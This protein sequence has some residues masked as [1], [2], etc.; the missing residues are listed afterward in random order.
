MDILTQGNSETMSCL[1]IAIWFQFWR[2]YSYSNEM[3]LFYPQ[4]SVLASKLNFI[5]LQGGDATLIRIL[6]ELD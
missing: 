3:I 4:F 1:A 5:N 6:N 2:P